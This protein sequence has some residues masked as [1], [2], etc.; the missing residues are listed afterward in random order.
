MSISVCL[1]WA[2]TGCPNNSCNGVDVSAYAIFIKTLLPVIL[3]LYLELTSL[4]ICISKFNN[5]AIFWDKAIVF[6]CCSLLANFWF[7]SFWYLGLSKNS[8]HFCIVSG[9]LRMVICSGSN[10]WY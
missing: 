2:I 8:F 3:P 6:S 1:I 5:D 7:T 9:E 10:I 4:T